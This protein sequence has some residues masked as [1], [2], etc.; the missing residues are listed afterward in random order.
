MPKRTSPEADAR[1]LGYWV[2]YAG[3]RFLGWWCLGFDPDRPD[4]AELGYR[5]RDDTW[6]HG[7][8][9]EGSHVLLDHAF[10]TLGLPM[11]WAETMAVNTG[12]RA[13]LAKLGVRLVRTEVREWEHPVAGAEHG[14][15]IYEITREALPSSP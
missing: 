14:E 4:T 2:G 1:G 13:V 12:S 7:Y 9:T 3:G 5:P 10:H 11:V 15:V 6:G 8:A